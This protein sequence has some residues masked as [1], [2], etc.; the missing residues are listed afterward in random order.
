MSLR[1]AINRHCKSCIYDEMAMGTWKQ[2]VT[3]CSVGCCELFDVRPT[4]V[5]IPDSV[6]IYYGI[7]PNGL[8]DKTDD[9]NP[10]DDSDVGC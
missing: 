4:T 3:L 2:Q 5:R 10:T 1:K 8:N 9:P 6:L 7:T